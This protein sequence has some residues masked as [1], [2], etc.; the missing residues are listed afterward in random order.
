MP[1]RPRSPR[2]GKPLAVNTRLAR[3]GC[4]RRFFARLCRAGA[5]PANPAA[6]LDL[7][8]RQARK[9]PE[10][11]GPDEIRRLLAV[12][13]PADPFG[14]RDRAILELFYATGVRRL[15]MA[16]LD[17]GDYD[18]AA[19]TLR[20]R[21]GKG[22]KGRLLPVGGRAAVL[23]NPLVHERIRAGRGT[24][25]WLHQLGGQPTDAVWDATM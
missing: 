14:L 13:N 24:H 11:F 2:G 4:V 6:D 23:K 7:P 5:I 19:R 8:R 3:L 21:R 9:L 17:H 15:E 10:G 1:P 16:G 25:P 20:I 18:P 12:P 22:G